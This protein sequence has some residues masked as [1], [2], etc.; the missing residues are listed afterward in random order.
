MQKLNVINL[1]IKS[2]LRERNKE[3]IK[4]LNPFALAHSINFVYKRYKRTR[5]GGRN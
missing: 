1:K 3:L 4:E 5:R 2:Q